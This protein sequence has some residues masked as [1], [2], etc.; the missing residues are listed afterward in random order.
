MKD[1]FCE[2]TSKDLTWLINASIFIILLAPA[3]KNVVP[4]ISLINNNPKDEEPL[5]LK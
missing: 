3:N 5:A 4:I 2:K 1:A